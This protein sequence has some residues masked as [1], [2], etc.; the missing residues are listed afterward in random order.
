MVPVYGAS[1]KRKLASLIAQN[2]ET[3]WGMYLQKKREQRAVEVAMLA[4]IEQ[5][6]WRPRSTIPTCAS[7][8]KYA[9]FE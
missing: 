5:R 1:R 3:F 9:V 6:T 7:E 4:V 8:T 2:N